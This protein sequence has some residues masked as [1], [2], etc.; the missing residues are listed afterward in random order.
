MIEE[1]DVFA[2]GSIEPLGVGSMGDTLTINKGDVVTLKSGGPAM[3][4]EGFHNAPLSVAQR[5]GETTG[6]MVRVAWADLSG[7]VHEGAFWDHMV[8]KK[9]EGASPPDGRTLGPGPY[10]P[11]SQA[12]RQ[13][14]FQPQPQQ[15]RQADGDADNARR[16]RHEADE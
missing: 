13:P 3:T 10:Q 4:V 15:V 14:V 11:A 16:Q 1:N 9:A 12:A 2:A 5:I 7:M 6:R 8:V